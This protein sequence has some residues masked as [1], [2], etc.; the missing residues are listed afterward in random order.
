MII[1]FR[2]EYTKYDDNDEYHLGTWSINITYLYMKYKVI[3]L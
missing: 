2:A 3:F 1:S